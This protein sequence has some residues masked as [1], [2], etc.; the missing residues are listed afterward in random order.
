MLRAFLAIALLVAQTWR[1][2]HSLW[3]VFD[4]LVASLL[5]LQPVVSI[6]EIA[7]TTLLPSESFAPDPQGRVRFRATLAALL[8][9]GRIEQPLTPFSTLITQLSLY[10]CVIRR[11]DFLALS[12]QRLTSSSSG[13]ASTRP[14]SALSSQA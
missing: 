4:N 14:T 11:R 9:D 3:Q 13:F 2:Q 5:H 12:L 1:S 7:A 6:E 10:R 8:N